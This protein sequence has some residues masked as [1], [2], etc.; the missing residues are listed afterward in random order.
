MK[1]VHG[2]ARRRTGEAA[3]LVAAA[4]CAESRTLTGAHKTLDTARTHLD[5]L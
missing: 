2:A 3:L 5:D 1:E 4:A